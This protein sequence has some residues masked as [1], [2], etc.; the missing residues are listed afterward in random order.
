MLIGGAGGIGQVFSEYLIRR[1]RAQVVWIGR[2]AVDE[3]I[4]QSVQRLSALGPAPLYLQADAGDRD[5]LARAHREIRARHARIDGIVHSAIVLLDK[6]IAN[7]EEER[8]RA[9]LRAKVDVCVHIAQ[10]FAHD[11]LDFVLFFSALQ[12]F[13]KSAGQSNYAAGCTFK[14]AFAHALDAVWPCAVKVVNWGFWGTVGTVSSDYYRQRMQQ[15]GIGSIEP[16][17]GLRALEALFSSSVPQLAVVTTLA[18]QALAAL[19][20]EAYVQALPA[21]AAGSPP[22]ASDR[23]EA[24]PAELIADGAA[25]A[26]QAEFHEQQLLLLYAQLQRL[27]LFDMPLPLPATASV[28]RWFT[29][30]GMRAFYE[31]WIVHSVRVL[32]EAGLLRESEVGLV[33]GARAPRDIAA[34]WSQWDDR[35]AV[36]RAQTG[37]G[38]QIGLIDTTLRALPDVLTGRRLAT[39]FLF[40]QS[41]MGS[42]EGVYSR[43]VLADHFN[44]VLAGELV[45]QVGHHLSCDPQRRLRILEIGAGTGGTSAMVFEKL[46]PFER[47]IDEYTYTDISKSFLMHAEEHFAA[48]V[49]YLRCRLF[50]V[51]QPLRNQSVDTG[52]YDFVIATNV[53]HATRNIRTTLRNAK[54]ALRSG[55]L[56]LLNETNGFNLYTHLTFGLLEGW[57]LFED[58]ALRIPGTPALHPAAWRHVLEAEGFDA[59]HFPAESAHDLGQQVVIARSDG[60]VTQAVTASRPT[61]GAAAVAA[62]SLPPPAARDVPAPKPAPELAQRKAHRPRQS[63]RIRASYGHGDNRGCTESIS[64]YRRCRRAF[65]RL[66]PGLYPRRARSARHLQTARYRAQHHRAVRPQ[67]RLET[68]RLHPCGACTAGGH[69]RGG[70]AH[71]SARGRKLARCSCRAG[72]AAAQSIRGCR[73]RTGRRGRPRGGCTGSSGRRHAG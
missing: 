55:G 70:R 40:P 66:R 28:R 31:R 19:S 22:A 71:S 72:G 8:L 37:I 45:A 52:S 56:L 62:S 46:R 73:H 58:E 60:I 13:V 44:A 11:E 12:S 17:E 30:S 47:S 49:P 20:A 41:K 42:V 25:R 7:M 5:D 67:H 1:H 10:V 27:G 4:E 16:D 50:N 34:V 32:T 2:R 38:A 3:A 53:L 35:C 69:R 57:W 26:W 68:R 63:G 54:A 65:R 9:A 48:A 43:N 14:D 51:E 23:V 33:P 39:D 61:A 24:I 36:W 21:T 64:G 6:S 29:A 18:P 59:V 15:A